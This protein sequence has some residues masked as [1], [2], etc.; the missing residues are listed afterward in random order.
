M[1]RDEA[2]RIAEGARTEREVPPDSEVGP[3]SQ[4][5][6]EI[7]DMDPDESPMVRDVLAW[8]VRFRFRSSWV[9]LAVSDEGGEIVRVKWSR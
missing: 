8:L 7:S 9:E 3:V 5:Y 4:Q 1:D 6:I 2:V